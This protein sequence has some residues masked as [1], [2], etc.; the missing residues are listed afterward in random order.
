[1]GERLPKII[2]YIPLSLLFLLVISIL[3][4]NFF[5]KDWINTRNYQSF[6][7]GEVTNWDYDNAKLNLIIDRD[8]V[9]VSTS[10]ILEIPGSFVLLPVTVSEDIQVT[11]KLT[12]KDDPKW[13]TAFCIGDKI[14]ISTGKV[15][16]QK[17]D[18]AENI[19]LARDL[20]DDFKFS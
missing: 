20:D 2:L 16:F 19:N 18:I 13:N 14:K 17:A 1:M 9:K 7:D 3:V 10:L 6:I 5:G 12:G 11:E 8:G 15:N 4:W